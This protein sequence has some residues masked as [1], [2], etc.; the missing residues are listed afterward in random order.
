[1]VEYKNNNILALLQKV[2]EPIAVNAVNALNAQISNV[3]D[4]HGN[5]GTRCNE[6]A[7]YEPESEP[8]V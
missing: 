2:E 4:H 8:V 6:S 7:C 3:Y 5:L 1:M